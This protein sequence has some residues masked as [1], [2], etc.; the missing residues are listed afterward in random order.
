M[1]WPWKSDW[2]PT[3]HRSLTNRQKVQAWFSIPTGRLLL[4]LTMQQKHW[5]RKK[6][7]AVLGLTKGD[8]G[9]AM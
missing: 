5:G 2:S 8:N 7:E 9:I 1:P 4:H 3:Q 6:S